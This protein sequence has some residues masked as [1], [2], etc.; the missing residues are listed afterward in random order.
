MRIQGSRIWQSIGKMNPNNQFDRNDPLRS[1]YG[2][3]EIGDLLKSPLY[4]LGLLRGY[5]QLVMDYIDRG[6]QAYFI[7]FMFHQLSGNPTSILRQMRREIERVYSRLITRFDRDPRSP[8]RRHLRPIVI[9]FPDLPVPK[10]KKK[11]L[12][13]V[14][15]NDGLHYN[16]IILTPPISRFKGTL[17]TH[18]EVDREQYANDK[19]ERIYVRPHT[20]D[21]WRVV[22]YAAKNLK[23]GKI[24]YDDIVLLPKVVSELPDKDPGRRCFPRRLDQKPGTDGIGAMSDLGCREQPRNSNSSAEN[25]PTG[26]TNGLGVRRV[27]GPGA[28]W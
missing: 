8:K 1:R 27:R 11:S 20:H 18:F 19:L 24:D 25:A 7:N 10:H 17:E 22:D 28:G 26:R 21:D 15:I 14:S 23:R 3:R 16:G 6:Y 9:L 2:Y 4:R 12:R 13:E 5:Q